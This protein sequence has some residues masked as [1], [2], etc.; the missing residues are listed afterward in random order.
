MKKFSRILAFTLVLTMGLSLALGGAVAQEKKTLNVWNLW[1]TESDANAK[2]FNIVLKQWQA[3]HPDVDVVIDATE[4]EAYKTKIKTAM[5]ANEVP[6]VFF[7][8][9]GGF[10]KPFVE[11][12]QVLALDDYLA[13]GTKDRLL[14]GALDNV[15][16]DGKTYGLTFIQ[17]V[18]TLYCNKE[19]FDANGITIP[20]TNDE[21]L[22]AVAAFKAKGIVPITV[23]AKDGWPAMFFQN[24][25][26][27]RTAGAQ[28]CNEALSG[29]ATFNAPEFVQ[30]AKYLDDLVK[31]GGFDP[32]AL[33]LSYDEATLPFL[34][35]QVP[36]IY[37]GSW[38]A[39]EIQDPTLSQVVDK[40]VGVNWPSIADGKGEATQILGGAIDCL[41]V[42]NNAKEKDLAVD[43]V[44]YITE[45][46]SRESFKLGAG[47]A[48]WKID[49]TG[50][51]VS[52]L[53]QN[54]IDFAAK[55]TGSVLAWDTFLSGEAAERHKSLVQEIF[56]GQLT[57]E[58]FATEMAK[59]Q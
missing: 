16:Y 18:G 6:D 33:A 55:S 46:M 15:T 43:F 45:N 31:A 14:G 37:Q 17:W 25:Y 40:V 27:V 51:E 44:K 2:S 11:A 7:A 26:A 23:G 12:G 56:A 52:P 4:N 35:G 30:S 58:D 9:G 1:T 5:A 48:T 21:L 22:A 24:V 49:M 20:T 29:A 59:L 50:I 34:A 41:M 8:W 39:G 36:M 32:G 13:D 38:L 47:I 53:V 10:A 42:S 3:L 57:P 28:L 54:I 19:M